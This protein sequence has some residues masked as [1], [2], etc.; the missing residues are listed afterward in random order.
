MAKPEMHNMHIRQL[1]GVANMYI[2]THVLPSVRRYL[3]QNLKFSEHHLSPE[4]DSLA[5]K[6]IEY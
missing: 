3:I 4:E 2:Y 1:Y 5:A 6:Y